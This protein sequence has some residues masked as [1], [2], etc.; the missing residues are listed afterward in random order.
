[1]RTLFLGAYGYGNLGDELCLIE[2]IKSFPSDEVYVRSRREDFTRNSVNCNGYIEWHPGTPHPN[3][4]VPFDRLIIGGGGLFYDKPHNSGWDFLCWARSAINSGCE[5]HIHNVGINSDFLVTDEMVDIFNSLNSISVRDNVS[6]S[7]LVNSGVL[8]PIEMLS[9]SETEIVPDLD[10]AKIIPDDNY[11]GISI[12]NRSETHEYLDARSRKVAKYLQQYKE[13]KILPIVSTV[14]MFSE[15]ENDIEGFLL[16]QKKYLQNFDVAF[17]QMLD[18]EWWENNMNPMRLKA[19]IS[20]CSLLISERKHNSVHAIS[21]DVPVEGI[22]ICDDGVIRVFD[23]LRTAKHSIIDFDKFGSLS[24]T[25]LDPKKRTEIPLISDDGI[26]RRVIEYESKNKQKLMQHISDRT[27]Y[28]GHPSNVADDWL[29]NLMLSVKE[30]NER[31]IE[32]ESK[33]IYLDVELNNMCNL[34]CEFCICVP[35]HI[36]DFNSHEAK[37]TID[38]IDKISPLF[39][40]AEIM[41]TSKKGEPFLTSDL[42][43]YTMKKIREVNP[44]VITQTVTNGTVMTDELIDTLIS[45]KLDHMYISINSHENDLFN[46]FTGGNFDSILKNLDRIQSEKAKRN[47]REPFLHFNCQLGKVADPLKVLDLAKK[48]GVIECNFIKTQPFE[49][50]YSYRGNA[51]QDYM[52]ASEIEKWMDDIVCKANEL[53]ISVNFPAWDTHKRKITG[54]TEH[55]YYP[56]TTKYF[57]LNLNCPTDAPWFRYCTSMRTVQP[58]CWSGP[59]SDWTKESFESI[60]NGSYL[61]SLR[62]MLSTGKYPAVCNCK[63]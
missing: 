38:E 34:K 27:D 25:V 26:D 39:K 3:Y 48:Y 22:N 52:S 24:L 36:R 30:R 12:T 42:F 29:S 51:A 1:M 54:S 20:K 8:N 55:F 53:F 44:F 15:K 49:D 23:Q 45:L 35:G 61:K 43:C 16:F 10:F 31:K 63:Y 62:K 5:V 57:D 46:K 50:N 21:C 40:Y 4:P 47:S 13:K 41:E 14:H 19:I 60:W 28:F 17:P 32:L 2:A 7:I 37:L 59:F 6:R 58:C 56:S 18:R 9:F 11:V 33:P